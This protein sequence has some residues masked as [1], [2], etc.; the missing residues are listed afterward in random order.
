MTAIRSKMRRPRFG[1]PGQRFANSFFATVVL[2][3]GN[4]WETPRSSCRNLR[5]P[6]QRNTSEA[7]PEK[8]FGRRGAI[9]PV[10][11]HLKNDFRLARNYLKGAIGD[12]VNL[13]LAAAAFNCGKWMN[14]VAERLLFIL[15]LLCTIMCRRSEL[16]HETA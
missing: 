13:L 1:H 5:R 9:E 14:A 10:T 12:A 11:G 2:K 7:K 4:G 6:R 8:N 15:F 3:A 16:Q